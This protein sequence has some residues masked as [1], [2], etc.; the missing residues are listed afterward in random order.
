MQSSV[1]QSLHKA[2]EYLLGSVMTMSPKRL[3]NGGGGGGGGGGIQLSFKEKSLR[4]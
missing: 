1:N 3:L 4:I 2:L